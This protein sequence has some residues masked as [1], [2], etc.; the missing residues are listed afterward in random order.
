MNRLLS[1]TLKRILAVLPLLV[2]WP[3]AVPAQTSKV[4]PPVPPVISTLKDLHLTTAIVSGGIPAS[5]IVIPAS[6]K[7]KA[8]AAE[9][10]AAIRKKTGKTLPV[11]TDSDPKAAVPLTGNL[12]LLGNRS[13]N[14]TIS[15][16]YNRYFCL[17]DLRYP[18]PGGSVVRT[19]HNPFGNSANAVFIGGSDDEGVA[20]AVRRFAAIIDEAKSS[21]GSLAIGR[22]ADITLGEGVVIP[23]D[24]KQFEIWEA[25]EGYK[26][27][28][29]FGWTSI[30]M[31]MAAYYMS[32]DE[33]HAREFLRLAF[34]DDAAKEE[35]ADFDGERIENKDEPLS[36]PYH[37][38]AH[39]LI[40]YW[41]LIE[42]SPV[43]SDE[44]RLRVT[45]AFSKQLDHRKGEGIYGRTEP[46]WGVGTR[47]GQWAAVSLY[48][49]SRYFDRDYPS[50]IWTHAKEASVSL[51][52]SLH[53]YAWVNGENDNLFWY[54]TGI[55][56]IFTYLLLSGDRKPIEN[57]VARTLTDA[58]EMLPSGFT[59]DWALQ[60]AAVGFLHKAAY[61]LNDGR[62][63]YYRQ[64]LNIDTNVTRLGQS[65]WPD[66]SLK[67]VLPV[68]LIGRWSINYLSE[69][70]WLDRKNGLPL[71]KSFQWGSYRSAPDSTGDFILIDGY[72][73]ESRNPYHTFDILQLRIGGY[74]VLDGYRNQILTD[75]DGLF[76]PVIAKNASLEYRD[77]I[78]SIAAVV[79]EVPNAAYSSWRRT[80]MHRTGEY[81]VI[82]DVVTFRDDSANMEVETLWEPSRRFTTTSPSPG[83]LLMAPRG[84]STESPSY[85]IGMSDPFTTT[86]RDGYFSMQRFAP[87]K[88][89]DRLMLFTL[90]TPHRG[91]EESRCV[92]IAPNASAISLP[93]PGLVVRGEYE[94][95]QGDLV[96]LTPVHISGLGLRRTGSANPLSSTSP[97]DADWDFS[98][99]KLSIL[100]E[101]SSE[102]TLKL[103]GGENITLDNSPVKLKS[104]DTGYTASIPA[105]R[106]T[107]ANVRPRADIVKAIRSEAASA[108][109]NGQVERLRARD[110]QSATVFP[111]VKEMKPVFAAHADS[112]V[113]AL[114][115]VNSG[116]GD[117]IGV[118][119]GTTVTLL[120]R[121]GN[122]VGTMAVDG[123]VRVLHWW[124][125]KKLLVAG[126]RDEQVVAF[127]ADGKKAWSFTSVMDLEVFRAAKTYW[128][129]TAPGHEGI[130]GLDSGV[131]LNGESQL[132]A[133][134]ACTIEILDGSGN[135][136]HRM[137]Q[138]WGPPDVFTLIEGKDGSPTM[139]ASRRITGVHNVGIIS[140]KTLDPNP[141]GFD[142]VPEG[143]T[144]AGGWMSLNRGH[145]FYEDLDGDGTRE[146]ISD[147]N[148]VWNRVTVWDAGGKALF[149]ASF[150]P[151]ER[152]PTK[153][154]RDLDII[155]ADNDGAKEIFAATS[156]GLVVCLDKTC[157]KRWARLLPAPCSVLRAVRPKEGEK[158][159]VFVGCDNGTVYLLDS[160]GVPVAQGS[161]DGT[162]ACIAG[163]TS[164]SAGPGV[165]IGTSRGETAFFAAK[166]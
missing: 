130:Q 86:K 120:N 138:F 8:L 48:C 35:I 66:D 89:G 123:P 24:K 117:L 151:G 94:G 14:G 104:T 29:Y 139:L 154:M 30:S 97:V 144:Y 61:L 39:L 165:V 78:G 124:P 67:P 111:A 132:F 110:S 118:A 58:L 95:I 80:I 83:T 33:Y 75:S 62:F 109:S 90:I 70:A 141:R 82:A 17:L 140:S 52:A 25:S 85:I 27:S 87:V 41:D 93:E 53:H 128:F 146:V 74:T 105:G 106:H 11:I 155:D 57:G 135:L 51:F 23:H 18:G 73:G 152:M 12:I 16:L 81:S 77:V 54:D 100:A 149:D 55:A 71:E 88:S 40:N 21:N 166:R 28:G 9:I 127:T 45:N 44:D 84:A 160:D 163:Y 116:K 47:H 68:N 145:M 121:N 37:Y 157:K 158:A 92:R 136:V 32:G 159:L 6:G 22:I 31:H 142:T 19:L 114:A 20:K 15:E 2:L 143:V 164:T 98:T 147:I 13:T 108:L 72:N 107:L 133:G 122:T 26:S 64:R 99:S 5:A 115:V 76:E 125:E 4:P 131:F 156:K 42:E 3:E 129:K 34:P 162:P 134:S 126:C 46:F 101:R 50:P 63:L 49:L 65:F 7:Y 112:A 153:T 56:P 161:L 10:N 60:Y 103:D 113:S 102:L 150:G 36:G 91:G 148:G 38:N 79:A 96:I 1:G 43:F 69:P 119:A 137:P 59:R